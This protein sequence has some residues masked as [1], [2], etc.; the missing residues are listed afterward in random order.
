MPVTLHHA[1]LE[2]HGVSQLAD[3]GA[4][5]MSS[6]MRLLAALLVVAYLVATVVLGAGAALSGE[7]ACS[8]V[9]CSGDSPWYEDAGAWQWDAMIVFG[10]ASVPIGFATLAAAVTARPASLP[11]VLLALH[12][13]VI[14][15]AVALMLVA[16]VGNRAQLALGWLATVGTGAALIYL[17]RPVSAS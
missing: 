2:G 17:R 10:I 9:E 1:V 4:R 6:R 7:F 15:L 5:V 16:S 3:G 11:T 8:E 12:A 14:G 13:S